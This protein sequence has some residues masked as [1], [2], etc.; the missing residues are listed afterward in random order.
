[1]K[2][3][4]FLDV[5]GTLC[6]DQGRVPDGARAAIQKAKA[7]GHRLFLCTGRPKAEITEEIASLHLVGMIG[8]GGTYCEVG[9]RVIFNQVF[10]R[11]ELL[12]LIEF[13]KQRKIEFYMGSSETTYCSKYLKQRVTE[14]IHRNAGEQAQAILTDIQWFLGM[15]NEAESQF[16]YTSINRL[17]FI[18]HDVPY[19]DIEDA[20]GQRFHIIH[21]TSPFFGANS[22]EIGL[23]GVRKQT[24]IEHL[25]QYL[26]VDKAQ[27]IALGDGH[28]DLDMFAAVGTGIAM[29]NAC[30]ELLA[31]ADHVTTKNTENGLANAFEKLGLLS[32]SS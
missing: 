23:K 5:D 31:V 7:N 27:A 13:L 30:E 29:G 3:I 11:D 21:S 18:N 19:Q 2:K 28:N 8:G 6:D 32:F 20:F 24:A 1:M 15:M 22:G 12:E 16:D 10:N 9:D 17:C 26:N 4:V 25:L 14:L